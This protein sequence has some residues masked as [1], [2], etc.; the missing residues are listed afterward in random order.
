MFT[1]TKPFTLSL[2][3]LFFDYKGLKTEEEGELVAQ[4]QQAI[5][6]LFP[7]FL[8]KMVA[9]QWMERSRRRSKWTIRL[10]V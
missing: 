1:Q 3:V 7:E 8:K 4:Q 9:S 5:F 2:E 6:H 10:D